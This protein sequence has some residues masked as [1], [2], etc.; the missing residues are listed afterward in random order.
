MWLNCFL[1]LTMQVVGLLLP[2]PTFGQMIFWQVSV[3]ERKYGVGC[4][5]IAQQTYILLYC[6]QKCTPAKIFGDLAL[7]YICNA[8]CFL[9]DLENY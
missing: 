3:V 7:L 4:C 5:C 1:L 6:N 8:E 9:H 2:N